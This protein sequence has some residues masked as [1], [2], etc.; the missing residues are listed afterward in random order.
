MHTLWIYLSPFNETQFSNTSIFTRTAQ[1][2]SYYKLHIPLLNW[3]RNKYLSNTNKNTMQIVKWYPAT[4][5]ANYFATILL[6]CHKKK[7]YFWS[8]QIMLYHG[9]K[10]SLENA[11]FWIYTTSWAIKIFFHFHKCNAAFQASLTVEEITIYTSC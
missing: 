4:F 10:S 5:I 11:S 3:F 8:L 6:C 7:I 9:N 1:S 2:F